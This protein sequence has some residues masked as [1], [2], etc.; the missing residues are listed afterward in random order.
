MTSDI[1]IDDY[2]RQYLILNSH[3]LVI[4]MMQAVS[5]R[6]LSPAMI[7]NDENSSVLPLAGSI[8][9]L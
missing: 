3:N 9:F 4:C 8:M 6:C 2:I 5:R 7:Y 1:L